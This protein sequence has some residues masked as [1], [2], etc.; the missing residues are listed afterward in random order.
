MK[1]LIL[2]FVLLLFIF[3]FFK[4]K[5]LSSKT[6]VKQTVI[7][8]GTEIVSVTDIEKLLQGYEK[9]YIKLKP[10]PNRAKK[11]WN[12][13]F[14]GNAYWPKNMTYPTDYEGKPMFLLAQIN[15]SETPYLKGYPTKGLL[16]F[17]VSGGDLQG[18]EF[19]SEER[20]MNTIINEHRGYSV[21]YHDEV[22]TNIPLKLN[23]PDNKD[24][25][26]PMRDEYS[27][28]FSIKDSD[29]PFPD[30][31]HFI[32]KVGELGN[33]NDES[34]DALYERFDS[35]GSKIGGYAYFTQSDPRYNIKEDWFLL[36]QMDTEFSEGVDI[37]WGDAGVGNF[38]IK[39]EDLEKLDFS[40]VWYNWD[41]H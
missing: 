16:Q 17:F 20:T 6:V 8:E 9:N 10:Q 24:A 41:C 32:N 33:I 35:S 23:F 21:I 36:F 39:P 28:E 37:M 13:K 7:S 40:K 12:S 34:W 18:L 27:L 38:F 15:F 14:G 25:Y 31:Y 4:G 5:S 19:P 2:G 3:S 11:I 1:Y 30:N 29:L 22:S 26:L